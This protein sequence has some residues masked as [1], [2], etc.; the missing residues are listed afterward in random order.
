LIDFI[1]THSCS[2]A[3][4]SVAKKKIRL[5]NIV[6]KAPSKIHGTGL[7]AKVSIPKGNYIGTY[8]GPLAKR[9]GT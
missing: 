2:N 9:D 4:S 1:L 7:F 3:D 8:E 6:Y 5:G